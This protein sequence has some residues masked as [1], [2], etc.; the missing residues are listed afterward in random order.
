MRLLPTETFRLRLLIELCSLFGHALI[1]M[2]CYSSSLSIEV[3]FLFADNLITVARSLQTILIKLHAN[4]A[5]MSNLYKVVGVIVTCCRLVAARA[6]TKPILQ[7]NT[8]KNF[9]SGDNERN[10]CHMR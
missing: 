8:S 10:Q 2:E 6:I 5:M 1:L 4:I 9:D 7:D 3:F